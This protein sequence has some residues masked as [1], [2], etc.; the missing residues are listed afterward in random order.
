[1]PYYFT[2]T[3]IRKYEQQVKDLEARLKKLQGQ[4]QPTIEQ[5]GDQWHD[6]P[7]YYDLRT[8]IEATSR[9][10]SEMRVPLRNACVVEYPLE[11]PKARLGARVTYRQDGQTKSVEILGYG[12]QNP[13]QG[14]VS[15]LSPLAKALIGHEEGEEVE[16]SVE[17]RRHRLLIERIEPLQKD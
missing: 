8:R 15:Y 14:K 5:C 16:F 3:G 7:T 4:V 10:L 17:T 11:T 6:N 9:Q 2:S 12:E 1:M 13:E